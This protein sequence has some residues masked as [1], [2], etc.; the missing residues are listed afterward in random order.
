ME[1]MREKK[2]KER[3]KKWVKTKKLYR[4]EA[5]LYWSVVF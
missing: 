5:M 3:G 1:M 4:V 2:K